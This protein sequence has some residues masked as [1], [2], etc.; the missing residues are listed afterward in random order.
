MKSHHFYIGYDYGHS[1]DFAEF[2]EGNFFAGA[3]Q[4]ES[5][6]AELIKQKVVSLIMEVLKT[7]GS[8][9]PPTTA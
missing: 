7:L 4:E 2:I 9:T 1:C 3:N 5:P 6:L 8:T